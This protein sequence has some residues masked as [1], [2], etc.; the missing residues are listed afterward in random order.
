MTPHITATLCGPDGRFFGPGPCELLR[1]VRQ[2]GSLRAAA[3][4]MDMAYTK[5]LALLRRAEAAMGCPLTRRA[6]GGAGGG[7][8]QLTP[9]AE[10]LLA[11]YEAWQAACQSE[12]DA[13]FAACF[14]DRAPRLRCVVMASGESRRFGSNKLLADFG[15]EPLLRRTL[16]GVPAGLDPVVVTRWE[17]VRALCREMG[18]R[19]LLQE[20]PLLSDTIRFGLAAVWQADGCLFLPGDQPLV[21]PQSYAALIRAFGACPVR[22][23]RLAWQGEAGSP[24]LFPRCEFPALAGLQG[25]VGGGTVL[26]RLDP[27]ARTV[28][29]AAACELWDADTPDRLAA[30]LAADTE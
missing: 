16:R 4:Q 11:R 5:A 12:A 17:P 29:A 27:P 20:S 30:L 13:L 15:G 19:C 10:A 7:G 6:V 26:R 23:V 28:E 14:S 18:V 22:P 3:Q 8:S 9:E 1:G 25:D 2:T 24:A 21:R